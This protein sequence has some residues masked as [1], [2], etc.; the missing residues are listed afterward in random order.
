MSISMKEDIQHHCA[1][2]LYRSPGGN[3][4]LHSMIAANLDYNWNRGGEG[5][6]IHTALAD[7]FCS[8]VIGEERRGLQELIGIP[9]NPNTVVGI[10]HNRYVTS[11]STNSAHLQPFR[12]E[13][14]D[15]WYGLG[16]NGTIANFP[17]L[18][19]T[20]NRKLLIDVDTDVIRLL[21]QEELNRTRGDIATAI[22]R[23][24]NELDGAFN[25]VLMNERG[26]G[27]GYRDSLGFHPLVVGT[28]TSL[29]SDSASNGIISVIASED[30]GV[31]D[32]FRNQAVPY[33]VRLRP[34]K[35]GELIELT[36]DGP[37]GTQIIESRKQAHCFFEWVYFARFLSELDGISV[38]KVRREFAKE[39]QRQSPT[40]KTDAV[41]IG[42]PQSG[43]YGG[44]ELAALLNLPY[45]QAIKR[46]SIAKDRS[47]LKRPDQR[48]AYAKEKYVF[49]DEQLAGKIVYLH[50]DSVVRGTTLEVLVA[51]LRERGVKEV[52]LRISCPAI[53]A[54]CF[55]GIDFPTI[56]ELI[57]GKYRQ[58]ILD[59]NG[60][61]TPRIEAEL[62]KIL[63]IDSI[64]FLSKQGMLAAFDR[65][66][67]DP[68]KLCT[69][70][71]TTTYPTPAGAER[72][73][74]CV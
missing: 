51:Q 54:P 64:T 58:E 43:V 66:G 57:V 7:K 15:T 38:Q 63:G 45:I 55:Y 31:Y 16:F 8:R 61:L 27:W 25:I 13:A 9:S 23:M 33:N 24:E 72:Y 67:M 70:C 41:M 50:E 69:A 62:C 37:V 39:L 6:G 42:V 52:H 18:R 74:E 53:I 4:D 47:F 3:A 11:G 28:A 14:N 1:L 49:N 46:S 65:L 56:K 40:A 22:R 26:K 71:V 44:E 19:Q 32:V 5:Y 34:V 35:A 2:A 29:V 59:N 10:G 48:R 20:Y 12:F 21:L 36:D 30:S 73:K 68:E 17:S 60:E